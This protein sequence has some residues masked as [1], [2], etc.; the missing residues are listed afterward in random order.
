MTDRTINVAIDTSTVL[1]GMWRFVAECDDEITEWIVLG[2]V[3]QPPD[4][5]VLEGDMGRQMVEDHIAR[6][7]SCQKEGNA[8]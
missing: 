8:A 5:S 3:L 1:E 2:D 4:P 7:E 6:C